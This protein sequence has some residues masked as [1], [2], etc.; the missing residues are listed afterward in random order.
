MC[1]AKV[2]GGLIADQLWELAKLDPCLS[3]LTDKNILEKEFNKCIEIIVDTIQTNSLELMLF[4][5]NNAP[6]KGTETNIKKKDYKLF[7]RKVFRALGFSP[8][9]QGHPYQRQTKVC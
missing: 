7:K 9:I 8:K 1:L 6:G 5:E 3:T 2:A 4:L